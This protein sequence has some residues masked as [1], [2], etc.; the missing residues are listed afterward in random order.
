VAAVAAETKIS[1]VILS[2]TRARS[3]AAVV[4]DAHR[5]VLGIF[6]DGDLRRGL[7]AD[8]EILSREVGTVMTKNCATLKAGTLA[9]EA[10]DLMRE[11]RIAEIP[12]V[13]E[14]GALAGMA[15]LKGLLASM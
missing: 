1:E 4:I 7:E 13:D 5:K 9:G 11:K 3:G 2:I 14:T 10:L 15:D 8:R 12:V 6:C